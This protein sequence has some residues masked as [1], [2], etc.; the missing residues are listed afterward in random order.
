MFTIGKKVNFLANQKKKKK[1]DYSLLCF[2]KIYF[3]LYFANSV[4]LFSVVNGHYS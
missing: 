2:Y 4:F 3:R 1:N